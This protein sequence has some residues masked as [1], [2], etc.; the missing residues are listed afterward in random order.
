MD[1]D[2]IIKVVCSECGSDDV[3]QKMWV[4]PNTNEIDGTAY[5]DNEDSYCKDCQAHNDLITEEQ[6]NNLHPL[7]QI[8]IED[9]KSHE[10]YDSKN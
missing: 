3:Q 6:W 5:L 9:D 7:K 10:N 4:N 1:K 2:K 8:K